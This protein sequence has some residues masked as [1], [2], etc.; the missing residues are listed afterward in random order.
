MS[1]DYEHDHERSGSRLQSSRS[2]SQSY[3]TSLYVFLECVRSYFPVCKITSSILHEFC[4]KTRLKSTWR[5]RHLADESA[6]KSLINIRVSLLHTSDRSQQCLTN[7]DEGKCSFIFTV[8]FEVLC[9]CYTEV[10]DN[11]PQTSQ[12]RGILKKKKKKSLKHQCLIGL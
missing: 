8:A 6:V 3:Q 11:L 7:V 12:S 9:K 1:V 2:R 10:F 5:M 4:T